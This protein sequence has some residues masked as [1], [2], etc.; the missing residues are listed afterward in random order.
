[1]I[2]VASVGALMVLLAAFLAMP[3]DAQTTPVSATPRPLP[4]LESVHFGALK[5]DV[6]FAGGVERGADINLEASLA[7]PITSPP[8]WPWLLRSLLTPYPTL[9]ANLNSAGQ[10]SQIYFGWTSRFDVPLA[11]RPGTSAIAPRSVF[12]RLGMGGAVN[13]GRLRT[14]D[15]GRKN[16]GAHL[17]FHVSGDVGLRVARH[18]VVSIYYDHSSNASADRSNESINVPASASGGVSDSVRT[19]PRATT[20]G[21]VERR[22]HN[23]HAPTANKA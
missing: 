3:V 7:A 18:A 16:L 21:T 4:W 10:T 15:P 17:L 8:T 14:S 2:R 19:A 5:H 11:I 20:A 22:P 1:M 9:G 13:N 6:R 23:H 12:F